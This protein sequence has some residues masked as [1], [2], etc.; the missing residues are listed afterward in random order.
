MF[1]KLLEQY[2]IFIA[3]NDKKY[4]EAESGDQEGSVSYKIAMQLIQVELKLNEIDGDFE[5]TSNLQKWSV[6]RI[7]KYSVRKTSQ[8]SS[9]TTQALSTFEHQIKENSLGKQ[10][11]SNFTESVARDSII[12]SIVS[13]PSK[14]VQFPKLPSDLKSVEKTKHGEK[15]TNTL[16]LPASVAELF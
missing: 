10:A 11:V 12:N 5:G 13:S 16:Q 14:A 8:A 4:V 15:A 3:T 1:W 9:L 6:R 2:G 7:E